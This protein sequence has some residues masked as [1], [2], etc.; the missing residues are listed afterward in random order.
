MLCGFCEMALA[1]DC[2]CIYE[3]FAFWWTALALVLGSGSMANASAHF[4]HLRGLLGED[5]SPHQVRSQTRS[6]L[7]VLWQVALLDYVASLKDVAA[8]DPSQKALDRP[9]VRRL[10]TSPRVVQQ[11]VL[12]ESKHVGRM[13]VECLVCSGRSGVLL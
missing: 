5:A 4:E 2:V 10:M 3:V 1:R 13:G 9:V 7:G 11:A 8:S 6:V 12:L